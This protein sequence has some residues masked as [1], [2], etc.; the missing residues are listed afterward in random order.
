MRPITPNIFSNEATFQFYRNIIYSF[1]TTEKLALVHRRRMLFQISDYKEIFENDAFHCSPVSE[2]LFYF[3]FLDQQF[4]LAQFVLSCNNEV[5]FRPTLYFYSEKCQEIVKMQDEIIRTLLETH[6]SKT[7]NI[8]I[9]QFLI[10]HLPNRMDLKAGQPKEYQKIN[11]D[12]PDIKHSFLP[13]TKKQQTAS[14][15]AGSPSP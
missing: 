15:Q 5:S 1:I 6:K 8:V 7:N 14:L 13:A 10:D 9:L 11:H 12:K 3:N 4:R 2:Y